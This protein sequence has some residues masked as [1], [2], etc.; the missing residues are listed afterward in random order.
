MFSLIGAFYYLRIVK[1]MYFDGPVN[2]IALVS[3]LDMSVLL[4][5]NGL[6]VLIL[7]LFPGPL[8]QLCLVAIRGLG[9]I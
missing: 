5:I 8:M 2:N 9:P 3:R 4:S 7:G 1:L 6:A